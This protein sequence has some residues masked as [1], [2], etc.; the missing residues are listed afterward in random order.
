VAR[1]NDASA[2]I[3]VLTKSPQLKILTVMAEAPNAELTKTEIAQRAGIGRTTLYR[4]WSDL[5]K[6]RAISP[7]RQV[8]A[9]TLYRINLESPIV[10]SLTSITRGLTEVTD[11]VGKIQELKELEKAAKREFGGQIPAG[12]NILV[13]LQE[14]NAM[15]REKAITL[16]ELRLSKD[17]RQLINDLVSAGLVTKSEERYFLTP[18]GILTAKGA[19]KIWGRG[20]QETIEHVL[21]SAK[22]ALDMINQ[23]IKK[24]QSRLAK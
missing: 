10:K 20:E 1:S 23:E 11:A 6:M 2:F 13:K 21:A 9:V 4:A 18:L 12:P 22:I 15:A 7:S 5:E 19:S 16:D 14:A 8:G 3:E 24:I 17:E